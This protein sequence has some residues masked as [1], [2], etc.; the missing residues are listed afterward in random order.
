MTSKRA[1]ESKNRFIS[2]EKAMKNQVYL[3]K[4]DNPIS[5]NRQ[6]SAVSNKIERY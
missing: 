4:N 1:N 5:K 6:Q 2:S 3:N